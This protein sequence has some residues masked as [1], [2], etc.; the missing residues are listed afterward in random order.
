ML[1]LFFAPYMQGVPNPLKQIIVRNHILPPLASRH[2]LYRVGLL[3]AK[4]LQTT[5]PV[6]LYRKPQPAEH[7]RYPVFT[8]FKRHLKALGQ[9]VATVIPVGGGGTNMSLQHYLGLSLIKL[10][11]MKF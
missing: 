9:K 7:L 6:L 3:K 10:G 5:T 11:G 2:V 4:R 8:P 1:S